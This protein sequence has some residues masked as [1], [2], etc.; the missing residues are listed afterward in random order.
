MESTTRN[1]WKLIYDRKCGVVVMLSD[2]LED[3]MVSC[4]LKKVKCIAWGCWSI[5]EWQTLATL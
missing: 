4:G 1:M 2:L 5:L 3:G